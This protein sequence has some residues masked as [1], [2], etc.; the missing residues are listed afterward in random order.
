MSGLRPVR[1]HPRGH[2]SV[3]RSAHE[4]RGCIKA[5]GPIYPGAANDVLNYRHRRH[6]RTRHSVRDTRSQVADMLPIPPAAR[7]R[8]S[9]PSLP[10]FCGCPN[11]GTTIGFCSNS[12]FAWRTICLSPLRPLEYDMS[13]DSIPFGSVQE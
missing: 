1:R 9:L 10:I 4:T 7:L 8:A 11:W 5:N 13:I 2:P 12:V 3:P 6:R